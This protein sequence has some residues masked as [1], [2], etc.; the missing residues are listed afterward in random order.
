MLILSAIS[1]SAQFDGGESDGGD[2]SHTIQIT[3]DGTIVNTTSLFLG[4]FGDGADQYIHTFTLSG[5]SLSSLYQGGLGDGSDVNEISVSLFGDFQNFLFQGGIGDGQDFEDAQL[6]VNGSSLHILFEGGVGDGYSSRSSEGSLNGT[7][8][9]YVYLGGI[10]DGQDNSDYQGTLAG[11]YLQPIFS[12]GWG[13]GYDDNILHATV[14]GKNMR[15]LFLGGVGDGFDQGTFNGTINGSTMS[16]LYLGGRGDG[17]SCGKFEFIIDFPDC[18]IVVNTNDEGFGSLR[19]A[20]NCAEPNDT[21]QFSPILDNDTINLLNGPLYIDQN[22][23]ITIDD[24]KDI[25]VDG[26]EVSSSIYIGT[27]GSADIT[28]RGL[29][30]VGGFLEFDSAI[31]NYGAHLTLENV[32]IAPSI[33]SIEELISNYNGGTIAIKGVVKILNNN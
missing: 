4:G 13:D 3:L 19:Y 16:S 21:I 11:D 28:I 22:L 15:N 12:G 9:S 29:N 8:L 1:S 10:G 32:S 6:T 31:V 27:L 14:D 23:V 7:F 25:T 5:R 2:C 18:L 33:N 30:I 17:F 24:T 20:I 26:S